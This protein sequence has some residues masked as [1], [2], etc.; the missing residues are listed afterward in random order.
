MGMP[1]TRCC[2]RHGP[3]A[4]GLAH[5]VPAWR[6]EGCEEAL[7]HLSLHGSLT[8]DA[9]PCTLAPSIEESAMAFR[10][11]TDNPG[12]VECDTAEEAASL[13]LALSA[14]RPISQPRTYIAPTSA[15]A[16]TAQALPATPSRQPLS[17]AEVRKLLAGTHLAIFDLVPTAPETRLLGEICDEL[18]VDRK[19]SGAF[20]VIIKSISSRLGVDRNNIVSFEKQDVGGQLRTAVSTSLP[21]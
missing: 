12:A 16:A 5:V 9:C 18:K 2:V 8:G 14:L 17:R 1:N 15:S 19:T 4:P 20:S 3:L 10:V 7:Q 21:S 6:T 13:S 11:R